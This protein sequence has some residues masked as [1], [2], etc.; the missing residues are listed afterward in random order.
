MSLESKRRLTTA[1][2]E[3]HR[4]EPA[5]VQEAS[6]IHIGISPDLP[7][8][9]RR[10]SVLLKQRYDDWL[11][12]GRLRAWG[13][14]KRDYFTIAVGGGNTIKAQYRAWLNHRHG[15]VDWLGRVRFFFLE[16]STGEPG[17]ESAEQSLVINFLV[18]LTRKLCRLR[19]RRAVARKLHLPDNADLESI[20]DAVVARLCNPINLAAARQ[21]LDAGRPRKALNL[22][23]AECARYQQDICDKLGATMSVHCIVSGI[24]KDGTLGALSPYRPEL[25]VTEPRALVL[26]QDNGA[27]RVALGRGVITNA[28]FVSLIVSGALKLKALGRLEM[29]EVAGFEQTVTETPLRMLRESWEIADRVYIF[30]DE[31]A[32]HFEETMFEYSDRGEPVQNKAETREG[33]EEGGVHALLIHGFLGLFSFANLLIRLPSSWTVSA[34]HRGSRAKFLPSEEIFPHYAKV[35]RKAMLKIWRQGRPV[36]V[37]GH[38]IA[39]LIMDHLLLT[40]LPSPDAP[41]ADYAALGKDDRDLVDA[42]RASGLIHLASWSPCDGPNTGENVKSLVSHW[43][44]NTALDYGGFESNYRRDRQGQLQPVHAEALAESAESLAG[45]DSFLQRKLARP[46]VNSM[47]LW[48]RGILNNRTVQQRMLNADIPYVMRLV[49]GRLL[50]TVSLYGLLKEINA[51]LHDP[52]EYQRRHLKALE[53]VLAYDIPYLS[54]VHRD[55]FLVSARRHEEEY[56]Y[57]LRERLRRQGVRKQSELSA[58]VRFVALE[59]VTDELS[60]DPLNPHLLVMSTTAEGNHMARQITAAMTRFVNENVARAIERKAVRALPSV[61]RWQ[62]KQ[63]SKRRKQKLA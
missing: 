63:H 30:A 54:I 2:H 8:A 60:V 21:A 29:D 20:I 59:R 24:G 48:I 61:R 50:K 44:R 39:G 45:L 9:A 57:L 32:L 13:A 18:P 42:L 11:S 17:W 23:R 47:N 26:K 12:R 22:A 33:D 62:G 19:G 38:S 51:G 53:I 40:L 58:T 31:T 36:P 1:L 25:A 35:L 41:V 16:D 6:G 46:L 3:R 5:L 49:G 28:E 52:V 7:A 56:R 34:L 37:A 15:D 10:A 27:L 55:D 14:Y 43:R 4:A